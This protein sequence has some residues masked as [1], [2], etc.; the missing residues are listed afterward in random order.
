MTA[1]VTRSEINLN[2]NNRYSEP[3]R[4][5]ILQLISL[6]LSQFVLELRLILRSKMAYS[7][8]FINREKLFHHEGPGL[9]EEI[10]C[11]KFVTIQISL[12]KLLE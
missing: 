1:P 7:P 3:N 6:H 8:F 10:L 12:D 2:N 5:F 11:L 4:I 9:N